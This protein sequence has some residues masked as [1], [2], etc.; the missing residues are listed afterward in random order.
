MP[1]YRMCTSA[2]PGIIKHT[3]GQGNAKGL[4]LENPWPNL[5]AILY[6]S[7]NEVRKETFHSETPSKRASLTRVLGYDP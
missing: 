4:R 1:V 5:L 6:K 7:G 2:S 3:A